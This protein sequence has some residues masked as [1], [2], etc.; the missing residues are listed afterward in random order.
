MQRDLAAMEWKKEGGKV[1][2]YFCDKVP[3]EM[4]LAAGFLPV[5]LSGDPWGSTEL[6]DKYTEP[7]YEGFV[8]SMLNML[9]RGQY[10]FLDYLIIPH[11]RDTIVNLYGI[12]LEI[13]NLEPTL[14][15]PEMYLFETLHT[16]FYLTDLYNRNRI[17]D[18]KKKLEDWK[19]KEIS[20]ESLFK[21]IDI[22]SENR[23]L[24]RK[25]A[26][27]RMAEPS[28]ISGVEALQIIG[29]SM[30]MSKEDHNKVLKQ[31]LEGASE[32]P[33]REGTRLFVAGTP[34]DNVQF[35]DIVESCNATVVAEDSCWGNKYIDYP[36]KISDNPLVS[37][38]D[39][40]QLKSPC[41]WM[42][43]MTMR[44]EYCVQKALEAKA[45]GA[46]FYHNE[47]DFAV[48]WDHPDLKKEMEKNGIPTICFKKKQYLISNSER[49]KLKTDIAEFINS[50]EVFA[51]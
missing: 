21:A 10:D 24:I 36:I 16:N 44:I 18:L 35:Y 45:Q 32:L 51:K 7:I 25:V 50:L 14:K 42:Y 29:S 26:E 48:T 41:T 15:L 27:L 23:M 11:S 8:R 20:N 43:P 47:W 13:K 4:I 49:E 33:V 17:R 9:L 38:E 2:G 6:A 31:F 34:M 28:R 1:V 3:E 22:I 12:L 37:I 39:A 5:R 30:F 46:I 40:H 19:G